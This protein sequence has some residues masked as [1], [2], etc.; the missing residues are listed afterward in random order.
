MGSVTFYHS[1]ITLSLVLWLCSKVNLI[2]GNTDFHTHSS[3]TESAIPLRNMIFSSNRSLNFKWHTFQRNLVKSAYDS[4]DS[5]L[6]RALCPP[7]YMELHSILPSS[8]GVLAIRKGKKN[9]KTVKDLFTG[10]TS[11]SEFQHQI[12]TKCYLIH[13]TANKAV[14]MVQ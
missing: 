13:T 4:I 10:E 1:F 12:K 7:L 9:D 2:Q 14:L 6:T 8:T 3:L 5:Y 11:F